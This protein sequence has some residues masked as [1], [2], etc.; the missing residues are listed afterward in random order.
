MISRP[1]LP[2]LASLALAVLTGLLIGAGQAP[3]GVWPATIAGLASRP[4]T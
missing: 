4:V 2:T 1:P 3:M